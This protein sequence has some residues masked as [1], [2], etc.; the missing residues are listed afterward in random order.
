MSS[1]RSILANVS[2][3]ER[4][5]FLEGMSFA[6]GKLINVKLGAI[7]GALTEREVKT[8]MQE[9][10]TTLVGFACHPY[11]AGECIALD[12]HACNAAACKGSQGAT[13][14]Q[15]GSLLE[16]I[17]P[18]AREHFLESLNFEKGRVT[19]ADR[20]V[21]HEHLDEAARAQLPHLPSQ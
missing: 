13:I 21:L 12:G 8:L 4:T 17:P 10:G 3:T 2:P 15:L 20:R 11:K 7:Q 5:R 6:D 19:G 16:G 18:R 9:C 1:F 14:V